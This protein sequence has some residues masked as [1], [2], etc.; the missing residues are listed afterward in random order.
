MDRLLAGGCRGRVEVMGGIGIVIDG[1]GLNCFGE[2][3]GDGGS[4]ASSL[5]S[6][7]GM[8]WVRRS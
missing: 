7:A 4:H 3:E 1:G 8:T 2:F 6:E 5:C